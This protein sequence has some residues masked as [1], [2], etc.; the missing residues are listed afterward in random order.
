M[1][2]HPPIPHASGDDVTVEGK[3]NLA[4]PTAV[5]DQTIIKSKKKLLLA[6]ENSEDKTPITRRLNTFSRLLFQSS[7]EET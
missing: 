6:D 4:A 5:W 2:C 7:Q 1:C 3:T